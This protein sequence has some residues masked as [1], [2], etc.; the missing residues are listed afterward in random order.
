MPNFALQLYFEIDARRD[1]IA[2][3]F[4]P[5]TNT[6]MHKREHNFSGQLVLIQ[7]FHSRDQ[8]RCKFI[9]TKESVYIRK[10]FN[11]HRIGLEHQHGCRFIVLE[12]NRPKPLGETL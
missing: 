2:T 9:G 1:G 6:V 5:Y 8:Y 4:V 11:F 3:Q 12:T 7:R 10:E